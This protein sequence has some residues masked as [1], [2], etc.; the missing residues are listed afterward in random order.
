[1]R[2]PP[3][4]ARKSRLAGEAEPAPNSGMPKNKARGASSSR[5]H[6]GIF[7]HRFPLQP[8]DLAPLRDSAEV[9]VRCS[10]RYA[11]DLIMQ[12]AAG[13]PNAVIFSNGNVRF[14]SRT[15]MPRFGKALEL[16]PPS[17]DAF[18]YAVVP[19]AATMNAERVMAMRARIGSRAQRG[20]VWIFAGDK[21]PQHEL[22]GLP[23]VTL[24]PMNV[25][26]AGAP[27]DVTLTMTVTF[28]VTSDETSEGS[29]QTGLGQ[30]IFINA[31]HAS[32][33]LNVRN[34]EVEYVTCHDA[35]K[36]VILRR[37]TQIVLYKPALQA[38]DVIDRMACV[39]VAL[40]QHDPYNEL[41]AMA[42]V[43]TASR[44][45]LT[46]ALDQQKPPFKVTTY[47]PWHSSEL[48][49]CHGTQGFNFIRT[50]A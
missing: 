25:P 34:I 21:N 44:S 8:L 40:V 17:E 45:L 14:T 29:Q 3:D 4:K 32:D 24:A 33:F 9:C 38:D 30:D 13:L 48:V 11:L 6:V 12:L 26:F 28:Y 18:D 47:V 15:D 41:S 22:E 39:V 10:E 23:C 27:L 36:E 5:G 49:T 20:I 7:E 1:M 42:F 43:W 2:G 46:I 37:G 16:C 35:V 50:F 19:C 31:V